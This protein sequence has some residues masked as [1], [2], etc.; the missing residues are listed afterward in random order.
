MSV[1]VNI[2]DADQCLVL[3]QWLTELF[4]HTILT[5]S[6]LLKF[7]TETVLKHLFQTALT[8]TSHEKNS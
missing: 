1:S 3:I 6:L 4:K 2:C 7:R 5:S 8:L